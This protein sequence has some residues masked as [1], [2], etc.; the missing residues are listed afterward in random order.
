MTPR[1]EN[2]REKLIEQIPEICPERA[3][4]FTE[5]MKKSEG[6]PIVKRRAQSLYEVLDRMTIF[7]RE[8]EL[9]VGNQASTVRGA[10]VFPE[11]SVQWILD[12]FEG[13]PYHF[14][15]RPCDKFTCTEQTKKQVL[16]T[17][18]YWKGK[19][20]I[21]NVWA[22]LPEPA[23][24][25]WEINAID[26]TWCAAAGLGNVLPD[27]EMVLKHGLNYVIEK[28]E[29]RLQ[30][31]DLT[32]PGTVSQYWFLQ[33]VVT[34]NKAVINYARRFSELLETEAQKCE[35]PAR[36]QELT[37]MAANLRRVPAEPA[38]TF[39]QAVQTVWLIQLI[40][41]IETNGHAIS[42][43]RFDQ[44]LWPYCR[45]DLE[46]GTLTREQA[47]E[48]VESFFIKAN[49]IN[50]LRSWPD[51]EYFPGY[52]LA[53]NL[54]IGGQTAD[55]KDAVNELTYIVLDATAD[56]K[57]TKP[58][59]SLKWFEGSSDEFMDRALQVEE[60]HK[61][62]QPALYNDL[63]VMRILKNMGV[64]EEDLYN[65]APVGCIEASIPGKWD[66][67]AKGSWLNVGKVFEMTLNNGTDPR[68]GV[69]LLP[70]DGDLTTFKSP[71]EIMDAF[72]RQLHYYMELQVIV[73]HISDEMHIL[74]DQNAFR[75]SLV[76]DCIERGKSL[77]EGGAVYT[78][79]GGPTAGSMSV[80]DSFAAIEYAVFDKKLIT[81]EQLAHAL[82]T[83]F[84]DSTTEPAGEEIRQLLLTKAPKFGNDDDYADKWA[85]EISEYLGSTY[86]TDFKSSRYGKGPIPATFALSQSSVTGNVAFGKSVGALPNGR[87]AGLPVNNGVSP[88]NGAEQHGPTATINSEGKLP[89]K[90]FQK[91]SIFN[92]RLT[93]QTLRTPEGRKRAL[94]LVKTHFKNYQYHI[95]FNVVDDE[96]LIEAQ[97]KPEEYRDL[98]VRISGYSAFFTP[99]NKELQND[100]IQRMKFDMG[101]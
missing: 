8:G 32:E 97:E 67:A 81:A 63:G 95:Q 23:R 78:A 89:S 100:V 37:V 26:D 43:G 59:V 44:Y 83:N 7:V 27:H 87:K 12:E 82:S 4:L 79:D 92:M 5:S 57:L 75:S 50:K 65:W 76:H 33:A 91:G 2:L 58:S 93:P 41:Q 9:I 15:E 72:K 68:T 51:S 56:L 6:K 21:E 14:S 47:L 62:G 40:L 22:E 71:R 34:A 94:G 86:Q 77:V 90:W 98:M 10:P 25:A 29:R 3:V 60:Q 49:E 73:E 31:L 84:E 36:K 16:E 39:W 70:G 54:A 45:R 38:E 20:L 42:L 88:S 61:G 96:T 1:I 53:E 30:T 19:T 99:L 74:H 46:Q 13:N 80:G 24:T 101:K 17:I 69:T 48:I 28:A 18:A 85:V 66:F 35:D 52:H 11:Y 55:G 64:A